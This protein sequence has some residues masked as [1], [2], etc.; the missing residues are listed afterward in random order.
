[1]KNDIKLSTIGYADIDYD[2]FI[3][4]YDSDAAFKWCDGRWSNTFYKLQG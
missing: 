2:K 3:E 1:M 4:W